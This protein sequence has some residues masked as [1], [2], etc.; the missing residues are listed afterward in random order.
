MAGLRVGDVLQGRYSI[1]GILGEGGMGAVYKAADLKI[2]R[3]WAIKEMTDNFVDPA[4]RAEAFE[5][6]AAECDILASLYH[7]NLPQISDFFS[8]NGRQYL[9]MEL[10]EGFTLE[11]ILADEGHL[12]VDETLEIARQLSDVLRYLHEQP[13]PIIFRDLKPGNIIIT[14]RGVVKLID[15]GIA[16]FFRADKKTDTRALGTPGYAAPEQYGTGQTDARSDI[17]SLGATLHQALTG[18]NPAIEPF[19]FVPVSSVVPNIP[20]ALDRVIAKAV[21][22]DRNS[23]YASAQEFYEA[24]EDVSSAPAESAAYADTSAGRGLGTASHGHDS[25]IASIAAGVVAG[26]SASHGTGS[27]SNARQAD[28]YALGGGYATGYTDEQDFGYG[29]NGYN[30]GAGSS[31]AQNSYE[32]GNAEEFDSQEYDASQAETIRFQGVYPAA[33]SVNSGTAAFSKTRIDFGR[34]KRGEPV[35]EAITLNGFA[36]GA[37]VSSDSRWLRVSPDYVNGT[38]EIIAVTVDTSVL[39][40]AGR[41]EGT[42]SYNDN[43][44]EVSITI[45]EANR[46]VMLTGILCLIFSAISSLSTFLLFS[47]STVWRFLGSMNLLANAAFIP[48][49]WLLFA[50]NRSKKEGKTLL[51]YASISSGLFVLVLLISLLIYSILN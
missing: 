37:V 48:V 12:S 24:L 20:R 38:D 49:S 36:E 18:I 42:I 51:F 26:Y 34:V 8:E 46:W 5:G 21:A 30:S 35:S 28:S 44:A 29:A 11:K 47:G 23:R 2:R 13:Q 19:N 50:A 41:Y 7:P 40:K 33:G 3:Q 4:E 14:S 9:V 43:T 6:F 32:K 22:M 15:F 16:R 10:V 25:D 27:H 45:E 31:Y 1:E 39:T 17:Y